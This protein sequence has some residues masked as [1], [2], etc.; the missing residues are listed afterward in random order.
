MSCSPILRLIVSTLAVLAMVLP[1]HAETSEGERLLREAFRGF[2]VIGL[3]KAGSG[4]PVTEVRRD[5]DG[6]NQRAMLV[7]YLDAEYAAEHARG[8]SLADELEGVPLNAADVYFH[9]NGNVIWRTRSKPGASSSDA[10]LYFVASPE[11]A[12]VMSTIDGQ[13]RIPM[14]ADEASAE[15][16]RENVA[17]GF[18]ES[19]QAM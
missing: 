5:A 8:S 14:F 19:G 12:P 2:N 13:S 18:A 15:S 3:A 10:H 11:G 6:S 1:V 4:D 16:Y 7:V 17:P 9:A